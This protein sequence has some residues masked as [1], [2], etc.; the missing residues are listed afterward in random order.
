MTQESLNLIVGLFYVVALVV[1]LVFLSWF[2][3]QQRKHRDAA[4]RDILAKLAAGL[5]LTSKDIVHIGQAYNI[6]PHQSR[7]IVY[8]IYGQ[9]NNEKEFMLLKSLIDDIEKEE[10]F[11]NLPDEVKPSLV[12][13]TQLLSNSS[14]ELD[15]HILTPVV[16]ALSRYIEQR[17][18]QEKLKKQTNRAYMVTVFS[19]MVGAIS[20]YFTVTAPSAEEIAKALMETKQAQVTLSDE[21]ASPQG[22]KSVR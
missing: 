9:T 22:P 19:F 18:E 13:I 5:T 10:P 15:K 12:R 8:R 6:S 1:A 7:T 16:Q 4:Q 17:G 11:D 20:F 14:E 2:A 3:I 21:T